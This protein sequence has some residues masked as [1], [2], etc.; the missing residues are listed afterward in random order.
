[1][2][3]AHVDVGSVYKSEKLGTLSFEQFPTITF[4]TTFEGLESIE[5]IHHF[6]ILIFFY[7]YK[8]V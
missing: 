8:N 1:M 2:G 4:M 3:S 6:L 5:R 7:L